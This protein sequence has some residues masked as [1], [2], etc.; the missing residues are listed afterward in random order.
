MTKKQKQ[1]IMSASAAI[2]GKRKW[3]S[4]TDAQRKELI[5]RMVAARQAKR[6]EKA[7]R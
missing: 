1:A 4:M 7:S 2:N 5:D 3:D 6:A